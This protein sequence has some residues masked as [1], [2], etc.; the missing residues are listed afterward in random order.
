MFVY[1]MIQ[2]IGDKNMKDV[3][4]VLQRLIDERGL[5][6]VADMLGHTNSLRLQ[7]WISAGKI[8]DAQIGPVK[9]VLSAT[10]ELS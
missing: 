2:I 10:G 5:L 1:K 8:P 9:A 6:Q 4:K 7:R 3:F